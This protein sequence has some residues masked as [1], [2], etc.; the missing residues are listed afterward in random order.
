VIFSERETVG[1]PSVVC[2]L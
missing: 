2:G 1:R